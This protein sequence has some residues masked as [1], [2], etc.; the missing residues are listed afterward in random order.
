[1]EEMRGRLLNDPRIDKDTVRVR[2]LRFAAYAFEVA[3]YACVL[4]TE[5]EPSLAVQE[6]LLIEMLRILERHGSGLALP[7]HTTYLQGRVETPEP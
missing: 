2:L 3:A 6:E 4:V 1:M 5:Y 7:S